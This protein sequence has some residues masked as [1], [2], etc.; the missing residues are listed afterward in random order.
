MKK[1]ARVLRIPFTI[2]VGLIVA[3]IAFYWFITD[4]QE[5]YSIPIIIYWL[6]DV[7]GWMGFFILISIVIGAFAGGICYWFFSWLAGESD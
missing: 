6:P 3:C 2:I 4:P 5:S 1:T 7:I